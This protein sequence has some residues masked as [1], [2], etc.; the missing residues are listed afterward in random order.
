VKRLREESNLARRFEVE[1]AEPLGSSRRS[2]SL[3]RDRDYRYFEKPAGIV[4]AS[5]TLTYETPLT[6]SRFKGRQGRWRH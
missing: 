3:R 1:A 6:R 4:T 5:S 2:G